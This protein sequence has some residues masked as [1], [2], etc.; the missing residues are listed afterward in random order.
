[1]RRHL[2]DDLVGQDL[3]RQGIAEVHAGNLVDATVGDG[4]DTGGLLGSIATVGDAGDA[5]TSPLGGL[6]VEALNGEYVAEAHAPG[7]LDA[8]VGGA[9]L[10]NLLGGA[11]LGGILDGGLVGGGDGLL[12][13]ALSVGSVGD[14][15]GL[16][17]GHTLDG[18]VS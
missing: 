18:T 5:T 8:T 2:A 11:E 17:L 12:G 4:S 15:G 16:D 1:M 6:N 7:T 14:I 10:G 9:E 3:G 13:D